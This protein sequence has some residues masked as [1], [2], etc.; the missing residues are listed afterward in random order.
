MSADNSSSPLDNTVIEKMV[1]SVFKGDP[2]Q[3]TEPLLDYVCLLV[4]RHVEACRRI[5]IKP[6]IYRTVIEAIVDYQLMLKTGISVL[7]RAPDELVLPATRFLQYI[8]PIDVRKRKQGGDDNAP[9][10]P[11]T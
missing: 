11:E 2:K 4:N 5:E 8:S 7:D 1:G 3:L 9:A 10:P 6:E